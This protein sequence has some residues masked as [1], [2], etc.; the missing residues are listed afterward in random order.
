[1]CEQEAELPSVIDQMVAWLGR[2]LLCLVLSFSLAPPTDFATAF[3]EH[4]GQRVEVRSSHEADSA[5]TDTSGRERSCQAY[6]TCWSLPQ[7][8]AYVLQPP[9]P[10]SVVAGFSSNISTKWILPPLERPPRS[11]A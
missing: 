4:S 10:E 11:A 5:A 1:M 7:P 8:P 6:G 9:I 2:T 3:L